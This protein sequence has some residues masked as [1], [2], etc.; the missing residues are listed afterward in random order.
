MGRNVILVL[1]F[2][3]FRVSLYLNFVQATEL[4]FCGQT[5]T[6]IV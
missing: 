2:N 1:H 4:P 3:I 5:T 6:D